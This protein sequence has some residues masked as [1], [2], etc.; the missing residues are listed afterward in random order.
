M[1]TSSSAPATAGNNVITGGDLADTLSGLGGNDTLQGGLGADNM[2][3]GDGSDV[4]FVDEAGDVVVE[5]SALVTD[6]DRIESDI[7]YTLAANVENLDLN[8][9]AVTGTGNALNNVI[10]GNGAANQL[11]GGGGNDTLNGADGNDL[12]DGGEG[13]DTLNGGDENDTIIGGSGNDVI[14]VGGGVNTIVYNTVNFGNDTISSFDA[15]GGTPATQDRIDLSGLG[16]TA[17]NFRKPCV[18]SRV[19]REHRHHHPGERSGLGHS[20]HDPDQRHWYRRS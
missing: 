15:T 6:I 19:R 2:T 3:G 17:A 11:F 4:Y 12:L 16:V 1:L 13:D 5:T 20:G 8:G 10:N 18:R 7:S 14:D 9:A